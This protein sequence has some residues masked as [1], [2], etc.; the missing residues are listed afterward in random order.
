MFSPLVN[1]I[2]VSIE[3]RFPWA[4]L[5]RTEREQVLSHVFLKQIEAEPVVCSFSS[6]VSPEYAMDVCEFFRLNA[7]EVA[8]DID[9]VFVVLRSLLPEQGAVR[10]LEVRMHAEILTL[11]TDIDPIK[12]ETQ[13]VSLASFSRVTAENYMEVCFGIKTHLAYTKQVVFSG[14]CDPKAAV[15]AYTLWLP[16]A[17]K[18]LYSV[19]QHICEII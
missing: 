15:L 7:R 18:V 1:Y 8:L 11:P 5:S 17:D 9:G 2:P 10:P 14:A 4:S 13:A 12:K 3:P 16:Y 19:D 6:D